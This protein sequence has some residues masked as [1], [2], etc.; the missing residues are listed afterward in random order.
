MRYEVYLA[1][2]RENLHYTYPAQHTRTRWG[3][4]RIVRRLNRSR[5]ARDRGLVFD[6]R[7][8]SAGRRV[9]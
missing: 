8:V 6:C 7:R 3:A 9:R 1:A 4:F 5:F 2:G